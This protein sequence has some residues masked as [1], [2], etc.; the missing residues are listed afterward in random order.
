MTKIA[1]NIILMLS[2]CFCNIKLYAQLH[3]TPTC[4][5]NFNLNWSTSNGDDHYWPPGQLSSTYTNVDGSETDITI[6]FTGETSTLGFWSGN[7]PKIGTQSSYLY[8]GIDLLSNGFSGTGITCTITFS[9]PVYALSF[10]IHHVNKWQTNGDKYTFTGKDIDGNTIYPEFTNSPLPTYVS[11]NSTGIV[12]ATSNLTAGDNSIIGVNFS[13]PNYIQSISFVWEDCDT[14]EHYQPHATGIGNLSFCTPQTLDFDGVDDYVSRSP[15]L[16]GNSEITMMSWVKLDNGFNGGE[17]MGQPNF[18]LFVDSQK[19]LKA[20]IKNSLGADINSPDLSEALL[21]EELW[22]HVALKF[23][24]NSGTIELYINGKSIWNYANSALIGSTLMNSMEL[25]LNTDFEIGR[26]AQFENDYFE[27]SIYECRVYNKALNIKQ[28]HQQINQEIENNNENVRGTIIPKDIEGLQWSDLLLY[29]KMDILNTGFTPDY[30]ANKTD[31]KLHNMKTYQDYTAPLPY[32]TTPLSTGVYSE[33]SNWEH[34]NVWD[35]SEDIPTHSIIQIKGNLEF[36][37]DVNTIGL[38]ID[39]GSTL[40]VRNDSGLFNS[41]YL[42]LD[43]TLDLAGKSQLI[44]TENSTLDVTSTGILE[45]DL[46][47]TA[48]KYTYNYWSSPV[49]RPSDGSNNNNYSVKDIFTDVV[50][51]NTGHDGAINPVSI[52]DYWIWKYNNRLS[53]NYSSWQQVRSTG[54]IMAGEGFTM[55]GPGTGTIN[56]EQNYTIQGKPNNGDINLTVYQGND[57]LIGNPYPSALDAVKFIEDNKSTI[58]GIG[59]SNGTLYFWKHWGGGSHVASDYQGGYATFS[60]SGGVP[61]ASK[62][63]DSYLTSTGGAPADIPGRYIPIGQGFYT[64]AETDGIINFNNGQRVFNISDIEY[65]TQGKNNS[66]KNITANSVDTRTKLRIGFSSVNALRRQLLVTIDENAT[67]GYDWGYDS[68]YIDTQI[69]DIYWIIDNQKY[70]IQGVNEINEQTIIP[71][72][73][74]TKN[75]GY[76]SINIDK[77]ENTPSNIEVYLHD[78]E[79]EVYHDLKQDKYETYLE[80]GEYLNRFEITF[81][82]GQTLESEEIQS[83]QIEAY[84]SNEKNRIVINNPTSK[85]IES[86]EMFN[87]LGQSLFKFQTNTNNSYLKYNAEQIKAGNYILKIETEFGTISKKVLVNN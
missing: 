22:Y 51:L 5:Q 85:L 15:F 50:F 81:A 79:L 9:K 35:I 49:G 78:K 45:K 68:K 72:G 31:G 39:S 63:T 29:Y 52:A 8:N 37:T 18:R 26:N 44:Q 61:A 1:I 86:V 43:G 75:D 70:T 83:K 3:P 16:D 28:L 87:I 69:D 73:I 7:T 80:A 74:H 14:C 58:S 67:L 11:D 47:G 66:N 62:N 2:L 30:S 59:A 77:L 34:G 13:S 19:K 25:G 6:T 12:N 24:G 32:V 38:I 17:I 10:D 48:D 40:K 76:N 27:G 84:F 53:D 46:L 65:S 4:G 82:K 33:P 20:S 56:D 21:Q 41:W 54:D 55:K 23:D 36:Y 60:L 57:Y 64:T 71:L 42:K